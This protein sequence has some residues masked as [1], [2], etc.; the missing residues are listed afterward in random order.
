MKRLF[1]MTLATSMSLALLAG[2]GDSDSTNNGGSSN[3]N[4]ISGG[5]TKLSV[6]MPSHTSYPYDANWQVWEEIKAQTGVELDVT[7]ILNTSSAFQEKLT[8]T[9][10][11]G[12]LPDLIFPINNNATLT[13]SKDGAFV[14]ILDHLD[15]LPNFSAWYAE[16]PE[17]A[18][19]FKSSDG[20]LYQ[21]PSTG[22]QESNRRSW[23]YR[24]DIFAEHGIEVPET[25]DELYE[26]L[27]KLK[28]LYPDSYPM[29]FRAG[30]GQFS[31]FAPQW[32]SYAVSNQ[33]ARYLS[34]TEDGEWIFAPIQDEAKEMYEFFF[35]LYD[36]KLLIPNFL[37]IDQAGWEELIVSEKSFITI[38]YISRIDTFNMTMEETNPDF[39]MAY[40][41]PFAGGSNGQQMVSD[42]RSGFYG[43]IITST[44][45]NLDAALEYCDFWYSEE[46]KQLA[47]W[48]IDGVHSEEVDGNRQWIDGVFESTTQMRKDSGLA[49]YGLYQVYD[50]LNANLALASEDLRDAF[51]QAEG[52]T[53]FQQP[54]LSW[55]AEE[56]TVI[57]QY[58]V[59]ISTY[60]EEN[61]AKFVTGQRSFDEWDD[62]VSTIEG[63]G[64][65]KV[66]EVHESS[67]ARAMGN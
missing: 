17:T 56:K 52:D 66:I 58:A 8:T 41:K 44:T 50:Y 27:V 22:T 59:S 29:A 4:S 21:F 26:V 11:S 20:G 9:M 46:G 61:M 23:M 12:N 64:L 45:K 14:N 13:Y 18:A 19:H 2:C 3:N 42:L 62:F 1:S 49:T 54:V 47:S 39:K 31:T 43:Y 28:E 34:L 32:G 37:S 57:D 33:S 60:Y 5:T 40:M 10:V 55:N 6:L 24:E 35:K 51:K 65:D 15:K 25:D 38:D 36:E 53:T 48:G 63:M 16:N 7:A 67:Y 30:T